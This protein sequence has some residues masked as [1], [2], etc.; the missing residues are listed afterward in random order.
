MG[1]GI[2][3]WNCEVHGVL[4]GRGRGGPR[5]APMRAA[6]GQSAEFRAA[7]GGEGCS[8]AQEVRS[9]VPPRDILGELTCAFYLLESLLKSIL[10]YSIRRA[11]RFEAAS[12]HVQDNQR[13]YG[14]GKAKSCISRRKLV[15]V[16]MVLFASPNE[17]KVGP[18]SRRRR[19]H[20]QY[21]VIT[22]GRKER[23]GVAGRR[24]PV[25]A[26]P[27]SAVPSPRS[28]TASP[29]HPPSPPVLSLLSPADQRLP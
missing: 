17:G 10:G 6:W 9:Q 8:T 1:G 15:D 21:A 2:V 3:I 5:R 25:P 18:E 26:P 23:G 20:A 4:G 19:L 12:L 7:S 16:T 11:R 24:G 28:V 13:S 14:R 22:F 27:P 29:P